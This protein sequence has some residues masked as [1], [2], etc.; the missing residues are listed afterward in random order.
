MTS[1]ADTNPNDPA[2]SNWDETS[3]ADKEA[4]LDE[5]FGK[6]DGRQS[7][8][9][10]REAEAMAPSYGRGQTDTDERELASLREGGNQENAG[11]E[12][13]EEKGNLMEDKVMELTEK[14]KRQLQFLIKD[15]PT[16]MSENSRRYAK[17]VIRR[18]LD[19]KARKIPKS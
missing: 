1:I 8:G 17:A 15:R 18:M 9:T 16:Q 5:I 7:D 11:R 6:S 19:E 13:S 14:Q 10:D 12:G 3:E 4:E 2:L